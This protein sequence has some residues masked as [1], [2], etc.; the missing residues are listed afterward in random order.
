MSAHDWEGYWSDPHRSPAEVFMSAPQ[1]RCRAC[2]AV[3]TEVKE[4]SW[5]RVASRCWRPHAPTCD[6][7]RAVSPYRLVQETAG[8]GRWYPWRVLVC[9]A[10]LNQTPG[11]QA[12]PAIA[13]A[14][15][16]CPDPHAM[17]IAELDDLLAPL[18]LQNRREPLLRR[19]SWDYLA[20]APV[21]R[22]F[23]VGRYA[24][25][26]WALFVEGRT[27]LEPTDRWLAPYLG[28]RR[29]GGPPVYWIENKSK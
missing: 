21:E 25:D 22:V 5:G 11:R 6:P 24:L 15:A 20:G 1:R 29:A 27:D 16:R 3:Q 18:G 9:C 12:R 14:L 8:K 26:A 2:G 4:Y 19:L 10:M 28:W 7:A 23:G 17:L 13:R